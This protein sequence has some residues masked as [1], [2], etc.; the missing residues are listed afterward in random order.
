M[1]F[2]NIAS[3]S[4]PIDECR[5]CRGGEC[6]PDID[7]AID[8]LRQAHTAPEKTKEASADAQLA[9]W[10]VSSSV[11]GIERRNE[12]LLDLVDTIQRCNRK[13]LAKAIEIRSSVADK[14]NLKGSKYLLPT[15]LVKAAEK[16]FQY[17]YYSAYSFEA[18]Q[19]R[20]IVPAAPSIASSWLG[21]RTDFTGAELFAKIAD[22]ALSNARDELM[23]MAHTGKSRHPVLHIRLTPESNLL[24][25]LLFLTSRRLLHGHDIMDLYQRDLVRLV[26]HRT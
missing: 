23:L 25:S 1:K 12:Q 20:G 3:L 4:T 24:L 8:H 16:T 10:L 21:Y 18:W 26:S 22:V 19:E 2:H 13:L 17:I 7:G 11:R 14:D 5:L 15:A 6:Y 9:H